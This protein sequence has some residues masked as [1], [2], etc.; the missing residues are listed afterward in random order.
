[1]NNSILTTLGLQ[2]N[3]M[4]I[5]SKFANNSLNQKFLASGLQ[6]ERTIWAG[7]RGSYTGSATAKDGATLSGLAYLITGDASDWR[8]LNLNENISNGQNIFVEP[9]LRKLELRI[10]ASVAQSTKKFKATGFSNTLTVG[11]MMERLYI[12]QNQK[13]N[14]NK[15]CRMNLK[16]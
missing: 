2:S 5:M 4:R 11:N 6:W 7:G 10:R 9:L 13:K 12:L 3:S 8:E 16:N 15:Y 14:G 1:M